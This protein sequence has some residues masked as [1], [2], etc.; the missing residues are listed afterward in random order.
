MTKT[1]TDN[2]PDKEM[3]I[4]QL[5]TSLEKDEKL[6]QRMQEENCLK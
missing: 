1:K 4:K 2:V 6:V 5:Q 3:Q